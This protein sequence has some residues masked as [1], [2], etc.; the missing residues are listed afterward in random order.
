[1]NTSHVGHAGSRY[2]VLTDHI[3]ADFVAIF[4]NGHNLGLMI[5]GNM[6]IAHR[7]NPKL[8]YA[9][10]KDHAPICL[11]GKA[12]LVLTVHASGPGV[13][14]GQTAAEGLS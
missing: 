12:L 6:S 14:P 4:T 11:I 7:L 5:N 2:P 1:M 3:A 9:L 10:L 13:T 8:P